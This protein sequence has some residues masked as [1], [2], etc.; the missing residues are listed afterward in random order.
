MLKAGP[1]F[2][3]YELLVR[4]TLWLWLRLESTGLARL[5]DLVDPDRADADFERDERADFGVADIIAVI[6]GLVDPS[7][8]SYSNN[9]IFLPLAGV[10]FPSSCPDPDDE[11]LAPEFFSRVVDTDTALGLGGSG[12]RLL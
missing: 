8:R 3:E 1:D 7:P 9:S 4:D 2:D 5:V 12:F 6:S 10:L 11:P